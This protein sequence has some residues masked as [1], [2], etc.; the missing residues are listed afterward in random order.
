VTQ[1]KRTDLF[2]CLRGPAA[3]MNLKRLPTGVQSEMETPAGKELE[4]SALALKAT[5]EAARQL[6]MEFDTENEP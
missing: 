3:R 5:R 2:G 1:V 6:V 4:P